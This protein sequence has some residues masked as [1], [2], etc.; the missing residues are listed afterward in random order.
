M[1]DALLSRLR[2][3]ADGDSLPFHMPGHGR[4]GDFDS[5]CALGASLDVTEIDGM[6]NLHDAHG[7]LADGMAR[8]S[9]LYG[10]RRSFFL[11]NGSTC[12][13][14]AALHTTLSP[15]DSI[16][17]A[18]NCHR[19]V[20]S[21]IALCKANPI[22]L[23]PPVDTQSGLCLSLPPET[24]ADAI[25][26]HPEAKVLLFT[27][28]TYDGVVS[29]VAEI[30]RIAH[31]HGVTVI[32]DEAHGAH[33]GRLDPSIPS[34]TALGA[35]VVIQSFHKTLPSLTQTAVA[36]LCTEAVDGDAFARSLA[37]FET[38]SPSYLLLASL[39]D[40]VRR[41]EG[42]SDT[43]F[44][45]WREALA[46]ADEV[47]AP[48]THLRRLPLSHEGIF[49]Y[50]TSKIL[51]FCGDTD[52]SG[53]TLAARLRQDYHIET[54]MSSPT[55]LLCMTG[56][57]TRAHQVRALGAALCEIDERLQ[58]RPYAPHPLPALPRRAQ[59]QA[60]ALHRLPSEWIPLRQ[61]AG[62]VA[63]DALFAY[64]PGIPFVVAGEYYD[65]ATVAYLCAL[66]AQGAPLCCRFRENEP[67]VYVLA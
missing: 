15:D 21:G 61:A 44:A 34:A 32:V 9:A 14:L 3:Y 1:H 50:D 49:A 12:G 43:L 46:V 11:V 52:T 63:A 58:D 62:R 64:P 19:S 45:P 35:D 51:L 48:L 24:V 31:A 23:L 8:L 20:A 26:A 5:L 30:A 29:D 16:L 67:F 6:D 41:M 54:E 18:R 65:D 28:P 7:I 60:R 56:A 40:C 4:N 57:G 37:I 13:L 17:V 22:W 25:A 38:S 55:T 39:D 10:T 59:V 27:S 36:H 33:L 66:A 2:A 47:L 42:S 53:I